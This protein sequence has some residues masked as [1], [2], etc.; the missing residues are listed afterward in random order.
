MQR[1]SKAGFTLI[2]L[3]VVI[4]IISLLAAI[5]YA[6]LHSARAKARDSKRIADVGQMALAI[7]LHAESNGEFPSC[8][9]NSPVPIGSNSCIDSILAPLLPAVPE[10]PGDNTY[11]YDRSECGGKPVVYVDL[12]TASGANWAQVCSGS[13]QRYGHVF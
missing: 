3:L 8:G 6:S 11:Y 9:S 5:V 7:K 4:V 12:E 10:D 2:E 1:V 13:A